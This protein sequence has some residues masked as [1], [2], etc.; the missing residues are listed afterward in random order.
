LVPVVRGLV[1]EAKVVRSA[2][3][4]V[5]PDA[6]GISISAEE[7]EALKAQPDVVAPPSN[8]EEEIYI[9]EISRFGTVKKPPPCFVEA[10][11]ACTEADRPIHPLDMDEETFSEAFV[12]QISTVELIR[13][14]LLSRRLERSTFVQDNP[15]DFALAFDRR[16]NRLKG[17]A[18]LEE[19]RELHMAN[20]LRQLAANHHNL[21]AVLEVE[22]FDG[23]LRLLD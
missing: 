12:S 13:H 8:A 4:E 21:L 16:L 11:R 20:A 18:R 1:S 2:F 22:R 14:G 6:V 19:Q 17:F 3:T 7:L 15:R 5:D 23:I 10:L 9:R